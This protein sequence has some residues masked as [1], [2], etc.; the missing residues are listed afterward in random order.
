ME[1]VVEYPGMEISSVHISGIYD[2]HQ[3]LGAGSKS[4]KLIG[5]QIIYKTVIKPRL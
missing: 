5:T 3:D 1:T 2:Q 4:E